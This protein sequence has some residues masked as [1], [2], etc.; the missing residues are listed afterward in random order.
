M[1]SVHV[2]YKD[3]TILISNI[4]IRS[5]HGKIC[6][7]IIDCDLFRYLVVVRLLVIEMLDNCIYSGHDADKYNIEQCTIDVTCHDR[8][9]LII[10]SIVTSMN[11]SIILN[12]RM[13]FNEF[14]VRA[15]HNE[16]HSIVVYVEHGNA[17]FFFIFIVILNRLK[18]LIW[19]NLSP[20]RERKTHTH[21]HTHDVEDNTCE[22]DKQC[23]SYS[24]Y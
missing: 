24:S 17:P 5:K 14:S 3:E 12:N 6:A 22:W 16:L 23:S 19:W 11:V 18:C 21:T 9:C 4:I 8:W 15:R 7:I 1:C 20:V 13:S 2:Q 10:C